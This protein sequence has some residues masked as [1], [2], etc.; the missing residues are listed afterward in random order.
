MALRLRS[1]TEEEAKTIKK[2]SQ[3]RSE[4]ARLVERARI[5]R[6]D[7][8]KRGVA[9]GSIPSSPKKGGHRAPPQGASRTFRHP[10]H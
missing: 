6:G 8:R 4:Q 2:W 5:I 3:S 7:S 1:L 10:R 9:N